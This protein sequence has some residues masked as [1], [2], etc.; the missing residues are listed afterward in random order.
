M[1]GVTTEI[2]ETERLRL[3]PLVAGDAEALRALTDDPAIIAAIS[4]LRAPFT[5]DDARRLIAANEGGRDLFRG[6]RRRSDDALIGVIGS[7]RQDGGG[8]E[9]G[10]WIGTPFQRQGYA[11]EAARAVIDGLRSAAPTVRIVAE[12]RRD[13][14]TS[15]RILERLGFR[16]TGA[17]GARPGRLAL[18]L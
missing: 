1:V 12:C 16:P 18:E 4:F 14:R 17:A 15:W 5:V 10:Y 11:F 6:I 3:V 8:I 9:I 7:H 2:V 13:N